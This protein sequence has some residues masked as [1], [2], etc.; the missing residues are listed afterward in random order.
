MK[1]TLKTEPAVLIGLVE[2]LAIALIALIAYLADWDAEMV[3]LITG[4]VA[5]AIA[6]VGAF[7]TRSKVTPTQVTLEE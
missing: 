6:V 1:P 7:V 3:A 2:A 4:V 5:S